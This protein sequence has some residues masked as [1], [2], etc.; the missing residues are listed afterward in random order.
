MSQGQMVDD[1]RM[2]VG[3]KKPVGFYGRCGGVV[4]TVSEVRLAAEKFFKEVQ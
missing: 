1:V 4:P 3:E 2:A